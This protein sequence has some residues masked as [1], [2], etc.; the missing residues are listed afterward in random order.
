MRGSRPHADAPKT[1]HAPQ[2]LYPDWRAVASADRPHSA[3]AVPHSNALVSR[4]RGEVNKML[5]I[6]G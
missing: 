4:K 3:A 1:I 5:N 2:H 6:N